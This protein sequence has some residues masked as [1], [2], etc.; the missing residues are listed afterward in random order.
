EGLVLL[1]RYEDFQS[2]FLCDD[3]DTEMPHWRD[4]VWDYIKDPEIPLV[5]FEAIAEVHGDRMETVLRR[6]LEDESFSRE[7]L[8]ALL[9]H[10]KDPVAGL[11]ALQDDERLWDLLD[12]GP[13]SNGAEA[14]DQS[15][16]STGGSLPDSAPLLPKPNVTEGTEQRPAGH[17]IQG[18]AETERHETVRVGSMETAAVGEGSAPKGRAEKGTQAKSIPV[19]KAKSNAGP[20]SGSTPVREAKPG[21]K[22]GASRPSRK[23]ASAKKSTARSRRE[24]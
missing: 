8:Y 18:T 7:H 5:A 22:S 3:P 10:Y 12:G 17:R 15:F 4:L 24:S 23:L 13:K 9:L 19:V 2:V 1:P 6:V 16:K 21:N 20:K 14:A 11:E